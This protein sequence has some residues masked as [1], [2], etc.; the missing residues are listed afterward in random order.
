MIDDDNKW[1]FGNTGIII[2]F[3]EIEKYKAKKIKDR[4][5]PEM[6]NRYAQHLGIRTLT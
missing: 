6:L 4:F 3:E 2:P 1:Y 5:T